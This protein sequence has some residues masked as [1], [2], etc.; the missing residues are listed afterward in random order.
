MS[1]VND[2]VSVKKKISHRH[3]V[4]PLHGSSFHFST[5]SRR[6][7]NPIKPVWPA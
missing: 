7:L 2:S 1:T 5:L 3:Y 4:G 6:G